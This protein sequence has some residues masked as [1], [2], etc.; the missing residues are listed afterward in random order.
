MAAALRRFLASSAPKE[1]PAFVRG[2]VI[3]KLYGP[4][5]VTIDPELVDELT[6]LAVTRALGARK[7]PWT[8]LTI[9][10][11]TA[12]VTRRAIATY[13]RTRKEDEEYL[14]RN[15][16]LEAAEQPGE[17]HAPHTDWG[18]REHL[19]CKYLE[20]LIGHDARKKDTFRLMMEHEVGGF[21]VAELAAKNGTTAN[22]LSL[23]FTKL[24]KELAPHVSIMDEEKPRRAI[25]SVLLLLL[26]G[27]IVLLVILLSN[28]L[29]PPPVPPAEP[30]LLPTATVAPPPLP[31]P[32][33][34][35][36]PRP[37]DEEETASPDA[38]ARPPRPAPP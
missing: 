18:A 17:R 20:G 28:W 6:Q 9:P 34:V 38:S 3:R 27:G 22:A 14:D 8:R 30:A 11:W 10:G 24:R 36:H 35:A 23:R 13:F 1:G 2:V 26:L 33:P 21:S 15:P 4:K 16:E 12:R 19:I 29:A 37:S 31:G 32:L 25:L 7:L 5:A